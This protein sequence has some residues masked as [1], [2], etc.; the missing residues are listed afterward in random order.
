MVS[1]SKTDL[2]HTGKTT[3]LDLTGKQVTTSIL[4]L[5]ILIINAEKKRSNMTAPRIYHKVVHCGAPWLSSA[6]IWAVLEIMSDRSL[7]YMTN[8]IGPRTNL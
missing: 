8:G 1:S 3:Q 2:T 6:K 4:V 7:I 5:A